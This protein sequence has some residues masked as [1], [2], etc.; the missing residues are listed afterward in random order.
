[1][2]IS[3]NDFKKKYGSDIDNYQKQYNEE[4]KKLRAI[5]MPSLVNETNSNK[6]KNYFDDG[7][8]FGDLTK[9][10]GKTAINLPLQVA[11]GTASAVEG[12]VDTGLGLGLG[13]A[14]WIDSLDGKID[15]KENGKQ[16]KQ[17]IADSQV[18]N[19]MKNLGWT[20]ELYNQIESGSLVKRDNIAGQVAEGIGGMFPSMLVGGN[21][22]INKML[23]YGILG[24]KSFGSG[25]QEAFSNDSSTGDAIKYGALSAATE[26]GSEFLTGGIPG[27]KN[28]KGLDDIVA[29]KL[30][31]KTLDE[32]SGKLS[33]EILKAGYKMAGEA[34]EEALTELI[35]PLLKNMTYSE[36]EKINWNDVLNSA[37]IGGL[38]GGILE[39]PE[40]I[41]NFRISRNIAKN[42]TTTTNMS[43]IQNVDNIQNQNELLGQTMPSYQNPSVSGKTTPNL[44]QNDISNANIQSQN[45]NSQMPL[46]PSLT[47]NYQYELSD[48]QKINNLNESASKYFDNSDETKNMLSSISKII[49]DKNYNVVFD[50]T[51]SNINE[52]NQVNAQIK[53]L[54]NG[55]TEIRIN[56][57]SDQAGEFLIMHEVTHAIE[58]EPMKQLILDRASK[59]VEFNQALESL[60]NT[61]G[62]N[63]VSDEVVADIS[64]QLFGNQ[65]FINSLSIEKPNIF[66][67]LYNK[68]IELANKITGNSKESLF[69]K[70]LKN[71]WEQAYRTQNNNSNDTQYM[72]TGLKGMNNGIKVDDKYV[73]IKDRYDAALYLENQNY[74]NE[75]IRQITGWFKDNKGNWEFE[76]SDHNVQLKMQPQTNSSYK[77]EELFDAKTL[78]GMYPELK[79]IKVTFEDVKSMGRFYKDSQNIVINNK[80][81]NSPEDL[82]GTLLHEIQHYIQKN[83]NL[84]QGT[85]ILWGNEQYVNNKGEIEAADTKNRRNLTVNERRQIAPESSK[86]NPIH[87]NRDNILNYKRNAVEKTA[88]KLY[89]L[90]GEKRGKNNK[91]NKEEIIQILNNENSELGGIEEELDNSSFSLDKKSDVLTN[92]DGQKIDISNLKENDTMKRFH[93]NR[94]YNKENIITYRGTSENT[95]SNGAFYGLGL[96]TTLDKKYASQYGSVE[97]VDT[98]LLPDNPLI[99]KTQNDFH[100][101][102]Q[103]LARELGLKPNKMYSENYGV[104]QYIKKLGYDGLMIGTGK[105][106]DLISFKNVAEKFS[107][108]SNA[109]REYLEKNYKSTGTRT[110]MQ[111]I[112]SKDENKLDYMPKDPTKESTYGEV[113]KKRKQNKGIYKASKIIEYRD[114]D[115]QQMFKDIISNYD[116]NTSLEQVKDDIK[117]CFKEKRADYASETINYI[118]YLIGRE[119]ISV[120]DTLKKKFSNFSNFSK[121][122]AGDINF[123]KDGKDVIEIYNNLANKYPSV[124]EK[125]LY[126]TLE[127]RIDS[128]KNTLSADTLDMLEQERLDDVRAKM[129]NRLSEFVHEDASNYG[130]YNLDSDAINQAANYIYDSVQKGENLEELIQDFNMSSRQ[131]RKEKTD[132]Y[133]ELASNLTLNSDKWK[134]KSMGFFY[135]VNTMKRNFFDVMGKS[136]GSK[137][138][139]QYIEPIFKH[140]AEMQKDI[141]KYNEIVSKLDLNDAESTA[142]QMLGEYKYNPE[143]LV[144]GM[145]VDD[146][147][148]QNKLDYK[149]LENAANVFRNIYDELLERTNSVLRS[150]GYKEIDF[151][152]G[153]FPHFV[154]ERATTKFGQL[155]EKMG[156]KFKNDTL[157]TDIAGITEM[158]NPGKTWNKNAQQRKGKYT[159]F[160]VLKG[161]DNYIRVMMENIYFTEDIQKLRALEN[162]IRYQHSPA[163]I[164]REIDLVLKD[165]SLE[166]DQRQVKLEEI[167]SRT[168]NPL[169][170]LVTE[171]RDYTNGIANKKSI[172]D[173]SMEQTTNRK[174]YSLMQNVSNRLSANMVGLNLSS[175]IT[176]FI[177]ITQAT[178]EVKSKYLIKGLKESIKNQSINDGFELKSVFLTSRLNEADRL[179][180]TKLEKISDKANF[181]FDG[182]DSI[183]SNTIVRGMYYQN[184]EKGMSEANA[185]R[186]ADEF[187]R[188]LMA[189]RT[190]GEMPTIFNSKN[191]LIK[192]F[193]S[194]Q[195]EVNNQF[196]YMMKDVPRDLKDE[197]MN[198][199]IG[200]FVKMFFGAWLYNQLTEKIVGRKAA[201]SPADT[202][203]EIYDTAANDN[204]KLSDKSSDIL[205]TLTQDV[206]FVGS[207]VGGGRLP[208][209]SIANPLKIAKGESTLKDEAKKALY[210]TAMPFGGGQLKKTIEGVSMYTH[211]TP[212]SYTSSGKL[213]FEAKTDPLSITQNVLFGQYSSKEAREYFEKKYTPLTEKQVKEINKLGIPVS[214]YRKYQTDYS[215]IYKI[216]GDKDSNGKTI[217]GSTSGKRAY[218][219]M[220]NEKID[221]KEKDYLLSKISDDKKV[222]TSSQLKKIANDEE[223]YQSFFKLN[224]DGKKEFI[225]AIE[226][227]GLTSYQLVEFNKIKTEY[228]DTY[229]NLKAK[230]L[231][232]NY[233]LESD[234]T[235][236]QKYYLYSKEYAS[237]ETINLLNAFS[238]DANNYL[239][240][241]NYVNDIKSSYQG[242]RYKDYRRNSVFQYI[243]S[244][245]ASTLEK[246]IL[247]KQAGY[248]ITNY[249]RSIYQYIENLSLSKEQKEKLWKQLY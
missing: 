125:D 160:N 162:E 17:F 18:E 66:K 2:A 197:G 54:E 52:S 57:N 208:I 123:S 233:L 189:G 244:L 171:L 98:Q 136:D 247:F 70:D 108:N 127:N 241:V 109:W 122:N 239:N 129:L 105:D 240:T 174:I 135:K 223:V 143:T 205:E 75:Q 166:Y 165:Y 219:I 97:Q 179:Y 82:R 154:E 178:S 62:V 102:E 58:T 95:G 132:E 246:A 85:S 204:L 145:E 53:M 225:R 1:M 69:I 138:Y 209:S 211:K 198:K 218:S 91:I 248:S 63:D 159:D 158:F 101:W 88:E 42:Q 185:I 110:N 38:T 30:G 176:N 163:N 226:K 86:E 184:L 28:S 243:N 60:K 126:K 170:N 79:N 213:R 153:Y 13:V 67:R 39:A 90:L 245:K 235:S 61:Y 65:E 29:K 99:F 207:L 161:Y 119:K 103:E 142:V 215:K 146:F 199:L 188:D 20:D 216:K 227:E 167:Y 191:P 27:L 72:M 36:G 222:V 231:I 41:N 73:D 74:S 190:K 89:N 194:F 150:Q 12:L 202:I 238:V 195:L 237:E 111:K 232:A 155:L 117:N 37:I 26:I 46:S 106:T 229:V 148:S 217:K 7:Y 193:T 33:K 10:V 175:A 157:P 9:T 50:D 87:P 140:N 32:V 55:E 24:G 120:S 94:K 112:R 128:Q 169:N 220:N 201:F 48:N 177:P 107:K 16:I 93:Y 180:K 151:R 21:A 92:V 121:M 131:I 8:H 23:S 183:T 214:T 81:I 40:N 149:K 44:I 31:F 130:K 34:G 164:Q 134:D 25:M 22:P 118:K 172:L 236:E 228:Q 196:G 113:K 234:M 35:N 14:E 56:P 78:Y 182:I 141:A 200:A 71:K 152:E 124:F 192:I 224:S 114:Y 59:D 68:I 133:R 49:T 115:H 19:T 47:G 186:N 221:S 43:K 84:P 168:H 203:K 77:L 3:Y 11:K 147:I 249:K 206:P 144:T 230:E 4:Q 156:W 6:S 173:R 83:E 181:M 100:I 51:I 139:H 104:E 187:A 242:E 45:N 96:Y 116:K 15:K 76:I 5:E 212:G 137:F 80:L 210:Y 64:G